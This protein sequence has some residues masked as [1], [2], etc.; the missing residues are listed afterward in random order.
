MEKGE[1]KKKG[2]GKIYSELIA[3]PVYITRLQKDFIKNNKL[4]LTKM[5]R[6]LLEGLIKAE[7][8]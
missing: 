5:V 8:K 2:R 6:Q 4:C 3:Q 1:I 7:Q